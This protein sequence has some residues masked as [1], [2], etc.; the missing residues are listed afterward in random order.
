M[1]EHLRAG[2][3]DN[4]GNAFDFFELLEDSEILGLAPEKLSGSALFAKKCTS[5]HQSSQ[6]VP[7]R[8]T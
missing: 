6:E 3:I 5:F 8:Q 2:S 4:E 7:Q 1:H